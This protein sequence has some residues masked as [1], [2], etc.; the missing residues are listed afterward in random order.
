MVWHSENKMV[1][2][3]NFIEYIY[4]YKTDN[5]FNIHLKYKTCTPIS[6]RIHD[7][8]KLLKSNKNVRLKRFF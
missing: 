2:I 6:S 5:I 8:T 4:T 3:L 7:Y 1:L